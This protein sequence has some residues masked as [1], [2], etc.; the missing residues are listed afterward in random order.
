MHGPH[1]LALARGDKGA[2]PFELADA[3]VIAKAGGDTARQRQR[4]PAL[5]AGEATPG[6]AGA[7]AGS[8]VSSP[9]RRSSRFSSVRRR[10]ISSDWLRA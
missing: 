8:D 5:E 3:L 1:L 9:T 2:A 7:I 10:P 4:Q 6:A